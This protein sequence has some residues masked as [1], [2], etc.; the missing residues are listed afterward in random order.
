MG[1]P[2][3]RAITAFQDFAYPRLQQAIHSSIGVEIPLDVDW[4]SLAEPRMESM[5]VRNLTNIYFLPLIY[6]LQQISVDAIGRAALESGLQRIVIRN[7]SGNFDA[8]Q[9]AAMENGV[10]T[11]DHSPSSN[12]D[13]LNDR[14]QALIAVLESNL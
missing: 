1:L 6:A 14:V 11:I 3:Q 10:L 2:E 8:S 7:S 12:V 5:Y 4:N 13:Y 9:M